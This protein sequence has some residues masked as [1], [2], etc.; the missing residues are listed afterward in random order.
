ML[1]TYLLFNPEE[2]GICSNGSHIM[3]FQQRVL[4][5]LKAERHP[6][7]VPRIF[8]NSWSAIFW[9]VILEILLSANVKTFVLFPTAVLR[10]KQQMSISVK[11]YRWLN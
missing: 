2:G 7:P 6:Y 11:L 9:A 4:L 8:N 5:T 10:Y 1:A 3:T